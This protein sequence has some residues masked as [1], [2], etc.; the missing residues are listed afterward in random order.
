MGALPCSARGL[1]GEGS[2]H[3]GPCWRR[4]GSGPVLA[5]GEDGVT[6]PL[7]GVGFSGYLVLPYMEICL[8][9]RSVLRCLLWILLLGDKLGHGG[10]LNVLVFLLISF[11]SFV[12]QKELHLGQLVCLPGK[13]LGFCFKFLAQLVCERLAL[14]GHKQFGRL[15]LGFQ[16]FV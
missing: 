6:S 12:Q 5:V 7:V 14:L 9:G 1:L 15:G 16:H 13:L 8:E 4:L 2:A 3:C 11:K 10:V